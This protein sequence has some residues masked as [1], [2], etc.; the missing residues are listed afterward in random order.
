M[1][2]KLPSNLKVSETII[3]KYWKTFSLGI[4]WKTLNLSLNFLGMIET[5]GLTS[6]FF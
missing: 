1:L 2:I 5:V 3:K 4:G 6:H